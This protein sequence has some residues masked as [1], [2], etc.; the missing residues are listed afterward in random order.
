VYLEVFDLDAALRLNLQGAEAAQQ[1]W[2]WPEPYAH[3][4]LKVGLAHFERGDHGHAEEFFRRTWALLVSADF[5][6]QGMFL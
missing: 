2:P 4:L 1:Y 3:A 6:S 5:L